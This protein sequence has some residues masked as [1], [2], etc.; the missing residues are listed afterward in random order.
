MLNSDLT[1]SFVLL[2]ISLR[3][4]WRRSPSSGRS[5]S[6]PSLPISSGKECSSAFRLTSREFRASNRPIWGGI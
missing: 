2:P 5:H 3:S 1:M 6:R 4:S